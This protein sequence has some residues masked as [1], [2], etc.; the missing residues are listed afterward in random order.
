MLYLYIKAFTYKKGHNCLHTQITMLLPMAFIVTLH[1]SV[2][3]IFK[4]DFSWRTQPHKP[5]IALP[6]R[7]TKGKNFLLANY[8]LYCVANSHTVWTVNDVLVD[9]YPFNAVKSVWIDQNKKGHGSTKKSLTVHTVYFC[10]F[11]LLFNFLKIQLVLLQKVYC[12]E[13]ANVHGHILC[14]HFLV[15]H[16]KVK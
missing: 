1:N 4:C 6:F 9:P 8:K 10:C 3:C 7:R 15:A 2:Y 16:K 12:H 11:L 13:V 14:P 5:I